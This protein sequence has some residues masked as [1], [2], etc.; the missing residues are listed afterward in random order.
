MTGDKECS[1]GEHASEL[2]FFGAITASVTHE[3]NNVLSIIDQTAGLLEDLLYSARQGKPIPP[4]KLQSIAAGVSNQTA[5]GFDF[6]RRLNRFAHS[7]DEP[8]SEFDLCALT[9]NFAALMK[10][11]ATLKRVELTTDIPDAPVQIVSCPF[12]LQ[13]ALFRVVNAFLSEPEKGDRLIVGCRGGAAPEISF[14]YTRSSSC[15]TIE[16]PKGE[17]EERL[18]RIGWSVDSET[19]VDQIIVRFSFKGKTDAVTEIQE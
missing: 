17:W 5:R 7:V 13:E 4:E 9:D 19:G 3:L 11:F 14:K 16:Q 18:G 15:G 6:I 10:R 12:K 8:V 2:A 1:S